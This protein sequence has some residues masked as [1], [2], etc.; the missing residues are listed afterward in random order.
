M[1]KRGRM[2]ARMSLGANEKVHRSFDKFPTLHLCA[3]QLEL[4]HPGQADIILEQNLF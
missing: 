4:E 2:A 1:N 3:P